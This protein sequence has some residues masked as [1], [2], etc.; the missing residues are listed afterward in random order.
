MF[1]VPVA[2][3]GVVPTMLLTGTTL[4]VAGLKKVSTDGGQNRP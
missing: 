3:V 4:N 2:L 1:S